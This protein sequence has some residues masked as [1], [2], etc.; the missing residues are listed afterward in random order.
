MLLIDGSLLFVSFRRTQ[1]VD[2]GFDPR[3]VSAVTVSLPGARYGTANERAAFFEAVVAKGTRSLPNVESVAFGS[4]VP[5]TSSAAGGVV[6]SVVLVG[7][8]ERGVDVPRAAIAV[9]SPSYFDVLGIRETAGRRFSSAD[10]ADGQRVVI[11]DELLARRLVPNGR[12]VGMAGHLNDD[13]HDTTARTVVGVVASVH[14]IDPTVSAE[15]IVYLPYSQASWPTMSILAR[16]RAGAARVTADEMRRLIHS[17]DASRPVYNN[18]QLLT[19]VDRRLA[20]RRLQTALVFGF[21]ALALALSL[22]GVYGVSAYRVR[23][24]ERELGIRLAIGATPAQLRRG[25]LEEA[26]RRVAIGAVI[27][28]AVAA[29]VGRLTARSLFDVSP[30]DPTI[31]VGVTALVVVAGLAS[32]FG[33]ALSASRADPLSA[34]RTD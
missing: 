23:Q 13:S 21:A 25:V 11:V 34:L 31:F 30:W 22:L 27:G 32:S 29:A 7:S 16:T 20:L 24:Q 26:G 3:P 10:R 5:F 1:A 18:Q 6:G 4:R 28:V 17:V 14:T 8:A 12:V 15:P 9:V 2:L 33:P 19:T